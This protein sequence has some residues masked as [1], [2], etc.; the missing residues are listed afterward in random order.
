MTAAPPRIISRAQTV[1]NTGRRIKNSTNIEIPNDQTLETFTAHVLE[2]SRNGFRYQ[3]PGSGL[4]CRSLTPEARQRFSALWNHRCSIQQELS[5]GYDNLVAGLE[6]ILNF[7]V[8]S[9][10]L[11]DF[12]R[13]LPRHVRAALLRLGD[14]REVLSRQPRYGKDGNLG[15]LVRAP[16]NACPYKLRLSQRGTAI[17]NARLYQ[18]GLRRVVHRRRDKTDAAIGLNFAIAVQYLYRQVHLELR[19][20]L[21]RHIGVDFQTTRLVHRRQL[22]GVRDP[23]AHANRNISN[24]SAARRHHVV[25]VQ[26]HFL[27]AHLRIERVHLRLG[28]V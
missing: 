8:V 21:D 12:Q 4:D 9:H 3:A 10:R 28:S 7:V 6:A 17:G 16:D 13:L 26:L 19:R 20:M 24:N 23:V 14:K 27:L 25:V 2:T 5:S 18:H 22:R 11:P 1:A 15:A